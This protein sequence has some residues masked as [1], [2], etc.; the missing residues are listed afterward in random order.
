MEW[1][2]DSPRL[3][4]PAC[5]TLGLIEERDRHTVARRQGQVLTGPYLLSS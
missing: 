4:L 3:G 5:L 1:H 2:G